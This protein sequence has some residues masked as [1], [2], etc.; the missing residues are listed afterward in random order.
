M[1]ELALFTEQKRII[2]VDWSYF[3]HASIFF[4]EKNSAIPSTYTGLSMI[5]GSLKRVG[6]Q[7]DDT[8]II[9]Q[10][11]KNNWRKAVDQ[12][13]KANRRENREKHDVDWSFEFQQYENLQRQLEQSTNWI[14]MKIDTCLSGDTRIYTPSGYK[15]IKNIKND[16]K[17]YSYN[18]KTNKIEESIVSNKQETISYHRYNLYFESIKKPLKIT[19]EHPVFTTKGWKKVKDLKIND[20]IFHYF[21]TTFNK[22]NEQFFLGY[23]YGYLLGDGHINNKSKL[24]SFTSKDLEGITYIKNKCKKVFGCNGKITKFKGR[25]DHHSTTYTLDLFFKEKFNSIINFNKYSSNEKYQKGF[26]SGFFDAEGTFNKNRNI[27]RIANTKKEYLN[28][29]A[30]ILKNMNFNIHKYTFYRKKD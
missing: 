28:Y 29:I 6:V 17:V 22:E 25:K 27:I 8:V 7:P 11:G 24:I 26:V 1:S 21:D 20:I 2:I 30:K 18:L 23:F 13:Y 5:L 15:H 3:V 4:H 14:F 16:D 12:N 19:G 9:A 10:D